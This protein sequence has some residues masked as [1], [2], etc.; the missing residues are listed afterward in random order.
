MKILIVG[1]GRLGQQHA[2]SFK[3]ENNTVY[4]YDK[5]IPDNNDIL[6][7]VENFVYIDSLQT[8]SGINF[9][10]II[11]ST[12][13]LNRSEVIYEIVSLFKPKRLIVE[14]PIEQSSTKVLE[15]E[16]ALRINNIDSYVNCPRLYYPIWQKFMRMKSG[17][18][19]LNYSNKNWGF[20]CNSI[21]LVSLFL[22]LNDFAAL[23][24]VTLDIKQFVNSNRDGFIE[25]HGSLNISLV[26]GASLYLQDCQNA[27]IEYCVQFNK[28]NYY[29]NSGETELTSAEGQI[30]ADGSRPSQA[31]LSRRYT[32]QIIR[33][34][35]LKQLVEVTSLFN[36]K[37]AQ[38]LGA[39]DPETFKV[40]YT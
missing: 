22:Q 27:E 9:D 18:V 5:I 8:I 13:A 38:A 19:N 28:T 36:S 6:K 10:I 34:P 4:I 29:V 25:A 33:L 31:E 35:S 1:Y 30:Y 23:S 12:T 16:R 11:C 26:N 20:L 40:E 3:N 39:D 2:K 17:P 15:I 24:K 7:K 21:H 32:D 37:V 14:K